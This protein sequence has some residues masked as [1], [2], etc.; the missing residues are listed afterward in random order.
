[1]SSVFPL[2]RLILAA[3]FAACVSHAQ[4]DPVSEAQSAIMQG[5]YERAVELVR[6]AADR[7]NASAQLVLANMYRKGWGVNESL[8]TAAAWYERSA[9]QGNV[10]AQYSLGELFYTGAGVTQNYEK[11]ARWFYRAA[12]G[13]KGSAP[14]PQ[15]QL[16]LMYQKGEGVKEDRVAAHMWFSIASLNAVA[17]STKNEYATVIR[18]MEGR[19]TSGQ[20]SAA[21]ERARTCLASNYVQC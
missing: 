6:P 20:I 4:A 21:R 10:D 18:T 11:A 2:R 14:A 13:G 9:E 19:M 8:G 15:Y 17:A 5:N 16:G 3:L 12:K 1:M 7:G